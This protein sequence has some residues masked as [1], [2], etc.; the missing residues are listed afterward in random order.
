MCYYLNIQFLTAFYGFPEILMGFA[1][2]HKTMKTL[3]LLKNVQIGYKVMVSWAIA[4]MIPLLILGI[5]SRFIPTVT[6]C[7]WNLTYGDYFVTYPDLILSPF[8]TYL[9]MKLLR[10]QFLIMGIN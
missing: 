10:K 4:I 7:K 9:V 1:V 6:F 8:T 2:N 3:K 5:V